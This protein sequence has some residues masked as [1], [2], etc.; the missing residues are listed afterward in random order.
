VKARR[1][2]RRRRREKSFIEMVV[3]YSEVGMNE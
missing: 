2:P 3:W 1:E